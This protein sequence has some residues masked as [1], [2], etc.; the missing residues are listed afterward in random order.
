MLAERIPVLRYALTL[1]IVVAAL[2]VAN[3]ASAFPTQPRTG[4]TILDQDA[5]E[6]GYVLFTPLLGDSSQGTGGVVYLLNIFG[7]PVHTWAIETGPGQYAQLLPDGSLLLGSQAEREIEIPPGGG[8][9]LSIVDWDGD[10]IWSYRNDLLHHDFEMLPNGNIAALLYNKIPQE[11]NEEVQ[12]GIP[13]T[14]LEDGSIW[15]DSIIEIDASGETVWQWDAW[16]H[17]DPA[18]HVINA[19]LN[20]NEWTHANSLRHVESNP[21]TGSEAYLVSFRQTS[22]M[23]LIDRA[24]GDVIWHAGPELLSQQHDARMLE[25]GNVL[26]YSNGEDPADT[27]TGHRVPSSTVLEI[28]PRAADDP[29]VWS[30]RDQSLTGWRFF[31]PLIS[32]AQ[33]LANG[34]TLITEGMAGRIFEVTSA[35]EIVWEYVSPYGDPAEEGPAIESWIFKALKYTPDDVDFPASLPSPIIVL[36]GDEAP[37]GQSIVI[38]SDDGDGTADDIGGDDDGVAIEWWHVLLSAIGAGIA[39]F[40]VGFGVARRTARAA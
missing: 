32:G 40:A 13:E 19:D 38:G 20:R 21:V 27:P 37:E 4:V 1:I 23:V 39:F 12:G 30:Y 26:V 25:N 29:V 7:Q 2:A 8:G 14:E 11:L 16:E 9:R 24:T 5:V 31:S 3:S 6:P 22:S 15:S 35:G 18:N 34:N 17:I 28:D 33:R 36:T 10:E